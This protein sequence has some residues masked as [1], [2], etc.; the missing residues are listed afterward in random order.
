[1]GILPGCSGRRTPKD[2][3]PKHFSRRAAEAAEDPGGAEIRRVSRDR[4]FPGSARRPLPASPRKI[5]F[6][7][8]ALPACAWHLSASR[9]RQAGADRRLCVSN[10][11]T[12][13]ERTLPNR[14][15][16][17]ATEMTETTTGSQGSPYR[18]DEHGGGGGSRTPVRE[19]VSKGFYMHSRR[20]ESRRRE[21]SSAGVSTASPL[22]FI[23]PAPGQNRPA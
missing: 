6:S 11:N 17:Q 4:S 21:I 13:G 19:P 10:C 22:F 18:A 9:T 5:R 16:R 7:L 2:D 20:F 23:L 15:D 3:E 8:R 12:W 14:N 1:M